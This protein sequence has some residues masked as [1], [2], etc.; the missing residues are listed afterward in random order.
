MG[1]IYPITCERTR[2]TV[3]IKLDGETGELRGIRC[4]HYKTGKT[5]VGK[6]CGITQSNVDGT[7]NC[8]QEGLG[9]YLKVED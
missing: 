2:N 3:F 7:F 1:K 5:R 9:F 8:I 6:S 4:P